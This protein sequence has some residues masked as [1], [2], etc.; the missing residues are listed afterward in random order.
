MLHKIEVK[1]N[2]VSK[3]KR[4]ITQFLNKYDFMYSNLK[5]MLSR[6]F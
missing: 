1:Q 2:L 4:Q 5:L 6:V 3:L